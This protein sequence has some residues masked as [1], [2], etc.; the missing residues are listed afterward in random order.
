MKDKVNEFKA[1]YC[2]D[3]EC[4]P[5][6]ENIK[7]LLKNPESYEPLSIRLQQQEDEQITVTTTFKSA[8]GLHSGIGWVDMKGKVLYFV[9]D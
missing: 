1:K 5:F 9:L 2:T 6:V 3:F 4:F 8:E 7:N